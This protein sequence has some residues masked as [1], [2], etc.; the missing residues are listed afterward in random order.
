MK[1]IASALLLLSLAGCTKNQ[2]CVATA[3]EKCLAPEYV[4]AWRELDKL[5]KKYSPI[6]APKPSTEDTI[7]MRGLVALLNEQGPKEPP[8]QGFLWQWKGEQAK[9]VQIPA[10]V[11]QPVAQ[12][13]SK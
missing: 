10:P 5:N 3:D 4:P 7:R 6:P 8:K 1:K 12:A 9:W 13:P 2:P 11:T